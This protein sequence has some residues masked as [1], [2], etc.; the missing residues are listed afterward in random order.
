MVKIAVINLLQK[1][2]EGAIIIPMKSPSVLLIQPPIHDF[3]LYDLFLKPYGL[4]RIGKWLEMGGWKAD[5]VNALDYTDSASAAALGRVRRKKNGT[6]KFHRTVIP[7]PLK[8]EGK[9]RRFARYGILPQE[10]KRRISESSPD[11]ILIT[12]GMTYWYRGVAEAVETAKEVHPEIPVVVGGI[13]AT[14]MP[15]HCLRKTGA[16]FA[17]QGDAEKSLGD[18][19]RKLS[20]PVP[21]G[22]IGG[23]MLLENVWRDAGIIRLNTGCPYR[24]D[25]CA[26]GVICSS[27]IPGEAEKGFEQLAA[28]HNR[29]G[30]A[31]FAFYDDALLIYKENV[32]V[33]FL[34]KVIKSGLD[35]NFY[36]PNA[37]HLQFLDREVSRLMVRAGFR[38]I[39]LGFES[40]SFDFHSKHDDK[41]GEGDFPA[42]VENL[43][44]AGFRPENITVYIL[45]GLP[46]QDWRE[47]EE[48]VRYAAGFGVKVSL[49]EYS[50]VPGTPLWKESVALCPLPLEEEPLYHNNTFFSMEWEGFTLENLK[51]LKTLALSLNRQLQ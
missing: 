50:P 33:P 31:N 49:A 39:R 28:M 5:F 38:E 36:L 1:I 19:L 41:Y 48:S 14:L 2:L 44:S 13:Y 16:D 25:Y 42:A 11:I 3:A 22:G 30:T 37:V 51:Y 47:V 20:L 12:S 10:F 43:K 34:K 46:R 17:A 24:C 7:N 23:P 29:F 15:D 6:G 8:G 26:S 32:F 18:I 45:A 9:G 40:S 27:F 21:P 35:L 4:L